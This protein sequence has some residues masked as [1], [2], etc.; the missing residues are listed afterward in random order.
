ML[1]ILAL[2]LDRK[3]ENAEEVLILELLGNGAKVLYFM[4][5]WTEQV[6]QLNTEI[7]YSSLET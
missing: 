2:Q 6:V 1:S 5:F 3:N 4:I 7:F